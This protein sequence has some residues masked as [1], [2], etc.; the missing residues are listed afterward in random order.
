MNDS[1]ESLV[2]LWQ[3]S[4]ERFG[5]RPYLGTKTSTGFRWV[6]YEETRELVEVF[7]AGLRQLGVREGDRVALI[8]NNRVEW[9]VTAFATLTMGATLVP[10]YEAQSPSEWAFI[11]RD[12]G[13]KVALA[14]TPSIYE[15]VQRL[16]GDIP[17]LERVI[18]FALPE[19]DPNSYQ[20]VLAAG[21]AQPAPA[22]TPDPSQA[23][24]FIYTSGTTGEPKGVVLSH[25]NMIANLN[26]FRRMFPITET[27]LS[28]AFLPW[29]HVFGQNCELYMLTS[30]GCAIALNDDVPNLIANLAVVSPTILIS[31]PR[32]FN[33]IYD[34][35]N[36]QIADKPAPIRA[37][38]H[39]AISAATRRSRGESLGFLDT[40]ALTLADRL[41]FRKIRG[42]FGGRLRF[43]VVGSAALSK[44]V[45][46]FV[47]ALGIEVY[48]G[49]G[50][51]ESSP[52]I[53]AN[54]PG[55]RRFGSVG[56]PLAGLRVE[57]DKSVT[58]DPANGEIVV[59]GPSVMRG[60]HNR[61]AETARTLMA[62]GGLR[63]GDM[64]YIDADGFLY[65]T[66]RIK[67][68]Y[69]LENGRYVVP[70][71]LEE[72]LKL[73][74]F[75]INAMLYGDN[76]PH[77]IALIVPDPDA[78]KKWAEAHG[79]TVRDIETDP[80]VHALLQKEVERQSENF[81]GFERPKTF[82]VVREDFTVEN[83]LLGMSLKL[84]RQK[85]IDQYRARIDA[86]YRA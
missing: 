83:G 69:K 12:S 38:F 48:E 85:A 49:Y 67:E 46:E 40:L 76:K 58:E 20:A 81:K 61:P 63:T 65:I 64:G 8:S 47:D 32:I 55:H 57:I 31:V 73:S 7:R 74:P 10:M 29:A 2:D 75:I 56:K 79:H 37:L 84:K 35:V 43:T 9:A 22:V 13:A 62:D 17:S 24:G 72:Q 52:V 6:S 54:C 36:K 4:A 42:R 27:D 77:N 53:A 66:G 70:S 82:A 28:L 21:R 11:L 39:H 19:S 44:D 25:A 14:A 1:F 45:A 41:I 3:R 78:V 60:Y 5:P 26:T 86:L 68:Q 23:A 51:T 15:N 59:Y 30:A 80:K 71:A 50:M 33:R 34:G 16:Q 18:G